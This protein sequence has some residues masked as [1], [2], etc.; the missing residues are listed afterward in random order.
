MHLKNHFITFPHWSMENDLFYAMVWITYIMEKV[1]L[2]AIMEN[3]V[4][5]S[6]VMESVVMENDVVPQFYITCVSF[7]LHQVG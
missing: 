1:T 2:T 6:V 4:M 3:D 7:S 5:E